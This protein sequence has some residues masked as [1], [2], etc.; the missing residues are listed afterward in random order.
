VRGLQ[1]LSIA[2]GKHWLRGVV[3]YAGTEVI[4]FSSNLHGVPISRL[5]SVV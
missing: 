5:W 2:A 1:A 3:L 4:S